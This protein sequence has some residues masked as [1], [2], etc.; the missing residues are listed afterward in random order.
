MVKVENNK[1][2]D[3]FTEAAIE[4]IKPRAREGLEFLHDT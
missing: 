2:R 3:P 1:L 4:L